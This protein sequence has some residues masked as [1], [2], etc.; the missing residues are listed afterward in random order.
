MMMMSTGKKELKTKEGGRKRLRPS[1][2][3]LLLLLLFRSLKRNF[4]L[5]SPTSTT[6]KRKEKFRSHSLLHTNDLV[7]LHV[8]FVCLQESIIPF[9]LL[10]LHRLY[11]RIVIIIPTQKNLCRWSE[12]NERRSKSNELDF[13][14]WEA[15]V[16][17][18]AFF[19]ESCFLIVNFCAAVHCTYDMM[20]AYRLNP[21]CLLY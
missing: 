3:R 12:T 20:H 17:R 9:N 4:L 6:T 19:K 11:F 16:E 21:D 1:V 2:V 7:I 15:R 14:V 10:L 5:L 8:L 13:F 18:A